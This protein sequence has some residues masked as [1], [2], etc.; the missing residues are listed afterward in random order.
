MGIAAADCCICAGTFSRRLVRF[1]RVPKSGSFLTPGQGRVVARDLD[2]RYCPSCGLVA[3]QGLSDEAVDYTEVDRG[4]KRQLPGYVDRILARLETSACK[5]S[6][7]IEVGANDGTFLDLLAAR[8]FANRLG[9]EPSRSLSQVCVANGHTMECVHLDDQTADAIRRV[10]GTA[11]AI[12]CRHTLEHVPSP[13]RLIVAIGRLLDED[14]TLLMEV[15]GAASI[16]R[17][18][19]AY[20]LWDEHLHYFSEGNLAQLLRSNGFRGVE[21]ESVPHLGSENIVA[22]ARKGTARAEEVAF[23]GIDPQA[24]L[25]SFAGRWDAF[26]AHMLEESRTWAHPVYAIGASHPQSNFLAYAGLGGMV[27]A[28]IDDDP[29]KQGLLV[30]LARPTLIVPT[31]SLAEGQAPGTVLMT[32][33]GY[34]GWTTKIRQFVEGRGTRMVDVSAN[35]A[36]F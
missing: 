28:L 14:G 4:T 5:E 10:H 3:L 26:R 13:A 21:I 22:W 23:G 30:P 18:L 1:E 8:G 27:D 31:S 7:V 15:P 33:F 17:D 32:G 34:E 9:I 35:L 25:E 6:L 20:E 2:F 11:A 29:S 12:V 36:S 16:L 19:K 24:G